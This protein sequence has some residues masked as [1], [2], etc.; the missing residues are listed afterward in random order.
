MQKFWINQGGV[1][2]G[3]LTLEELRELG[4]QPDAY[5]WC[6]GMPDWMPVSQVPEVASLINAQ[7]AP[8]APVETP[9]APQA[10]V[11]AATEPQ[12]AVEPQAPVIPTIPEVPAQPQQPVQPQ[13][14]SEPVQPQPVQPQ[15]ASAPQPAGTAR[16][17]MPATNLAWA[18]GSMLICCVPLGIVA[19]IYSTK[20]STAF[21]KGDIEA[22]EHY[23]EVSAWWC[24]A[25]IV[26]GIISQPFVTLMMM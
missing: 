24:I 5:V 4:V 18:I 23:S 9:A 12:A 7:P 1:Q 17:K 6:T 19:I 22:A 16:A 21:Y 2:H 20:V 3:P 13:Y 25:T 11:E 10:P 26:L 15:Y 8:A 14:V